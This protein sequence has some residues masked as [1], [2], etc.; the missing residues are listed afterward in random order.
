[1]HPNGV[2]TEGPSCTAYSSCFLHTAGVQHTPIPP[3]QSQV[4]GP[5]TCKQNI[6]GGKKK[7]LHLLPALKTLH[8]WLMKFNNYLRNCAFHGPF[9]LSYSPLIPAFANL[10]HMFQPRLSLFS[11]IQLLLFE[12]YSIGQ[13]GKKKRLILL[14]ENTITSSHRLGRLDGSWR[15]T[16]CLISTVLL[17]Q[18]WTLSDRWVL[19]L[20]SVLWWVPCGDRYESWKPGNTYTA[21]VDVPDHTNGYLGGIWSFYCLTA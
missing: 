21:I 2:I 15:D 16:S 12:L 17:C 4:C 3:R 13:I 20:H 9:N 7:Y 5:V 14:W 18:R 8:H 1:M 19:S 11:L 6:T 10:L